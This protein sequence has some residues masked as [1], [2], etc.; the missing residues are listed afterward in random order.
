MTKKVIIIVDSSTALNLLK[1]TFENYSWEVYVTKSGMSAYDMIFDVAPDLIITDA[2]MPVMGGFQLLKAIRRNEKISKI[3][4]I[5]Y[6]VLPENNAKFY[7]REDSIE[8]F[9][10]KG[11]NYNEVIGIAEE[12]IKKY[13]LSDAYKTEILRQKKKTQKE[14]SKEEII[15]QDEEIESAWEEVEPIFDFET[16]ERE[17]KEKCDYFKEDEKLFLDLFS[18]LDSLLNYDLSIIYP[19]SSQEKNNVYFDIKNVILS[20]AFQNAILNKFNAKESVLFKKYVPN[21]KMISS[22]DDFN[23]KIEFSFDYKGVKTGYAAFYS[24]KKSKWRNEENIETIDKLLSKL[25][26]NRYIDKFFKDGKKENTSKKYY[27]NKT[28][29]D[30]YTKFENEDKKSFVGILDIANFQELTSNLAIEEL[31]IINSKISEKI[32]NYLDKDEYVYKN[33]DDEYIIILYAKD[34]NRATTKFNNIIKLLEEISFNSYKVKSIVGISCCMI[35][36]VF[37]IREAQKMARDA[38]DIANLSDRVV[39]NNAK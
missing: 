11:G 8:Y 31:D 12:I 18:L 26:K 15:A 1:S 2:I 10:T 14:E 13:P 32:I 33:D 25:F 29:L 17:F 23:S 19:Y 39:V 21:L 38:L 7:T 30:I 9:L 34:E 35:D 5:I 28:D 4:V 27:S 20:R 36:G 37:N 24:K 22:E 3:P 16:L 6:S